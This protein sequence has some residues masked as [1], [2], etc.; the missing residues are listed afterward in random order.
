M[1]G[2]RLLFS[3]CLYNVQYTCAYTKYQYSYILIMFE[4]FIFGMKEKI[5]TKI[6][7]TCYSLVHAH[8]FKKYI[9]FNL[10]LLYEYYISCFD[11]YCL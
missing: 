11:S 1:H 3:I 7:A 8:Y 6:S 5:Q 9:K 2:M 4:S 10:L